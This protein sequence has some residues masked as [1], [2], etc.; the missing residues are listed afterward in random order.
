MVQPLDD[1]LLAFHSA[2][3][4]AAV[5]RERREVGSRF[6]S[7]INDDTGLAWFGS[8]V[9]TMTTTHDA[10]SD[11]FTAYTKALLARDAQAVAAMYTVP[12]LIVSPG[13]SIAVSDEQQTADFFTGAWGQY[14]GVNEIVAETTV[15][16]Q[17]PGSVWVDVA[18]TYGGA[19]RE[20]FCYQLVPNKSAYQ[21][22]VLTP[23]TVDE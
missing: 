13:H 12:S 11:F 5:S 14:D 16:A 9:G 17:A 1:H 23:M 7:T 2:Q 15:I 19:A 3:G 6:H 21:I 20:R 10:I 8:N 18:F 4:E 22:A